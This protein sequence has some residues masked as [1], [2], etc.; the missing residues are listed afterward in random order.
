MYIPNLGKLTGTPDDSLSSY[1]R[2]FNLSPTFNV[3]LLS[4]VISK[5]R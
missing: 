1:V 2:N 5:G 3:T 4:N